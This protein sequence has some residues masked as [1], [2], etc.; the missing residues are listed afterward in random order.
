MYILWS[1]YVLKEKQ[2]AILSHFTITAS[3]NIYCEH[4][5]NTAGNI[6]VWKICFILQIFCVCVNQFTMQT[7]S[8]Q[9]CIIL[10]AVVSL[11][12]PTILWQKSQVRGWRS[13]NWWLGV[14][15]IITSVKWGSSTH[16]SSSNS[17]I[18]WFYDSILFVHILTMLEPIKPPTH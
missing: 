15:P 5:T 3:E 2:R 7:M 10:A 14:P 11:F 13:N 6:L 9:Y 1:F 17:D 4:S 18:L 12:S 8:Q 16:W